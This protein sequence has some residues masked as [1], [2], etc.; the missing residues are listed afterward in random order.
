VTGRLIR[1]YPLTA[2]T[3]PSRRVAA[4]TGVRQLT[5]TSGSAVRV[6]NL[7]FGEI[8]L[9]PHLTGV[10]PGISQ[11]PVGVDTGVDTRVRRWYRHPPDMDSRSRRSRSAVRV[12]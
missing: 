6:C 4:E 2:S 11:T 3:T 1:S 5:Q 9:P 12:C 7:V 10:L 8:P